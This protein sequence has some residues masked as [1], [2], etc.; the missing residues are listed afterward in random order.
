MNTWKICLFCDRVLPPKRVK[1]G[2][3]TGEHIIPKMAHRPPWNSGSLNSTMAD[4]RKGKT[5]IH[6]A[7]IST[8][9]A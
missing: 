6:S 7:T 3:K 8:L 1:H 5:I 4:G 2:E 9:S